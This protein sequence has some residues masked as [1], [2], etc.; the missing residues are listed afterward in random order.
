MNPSITTTP[1]RT[2][3]TN[4]LRHRW[5]RLAKREQRAVQALVL[6]A[7]LTSLYLLWQPQ[8]QALALAEQRYTEETQ[9]LLDLQRLPVST[10][11][12][13]G[14]VISGD[15]LPGMLA[16]SS[17]QA[18]L[19]LERM[20]QEDEGRVNLS[21]EGPLNGLITWID[22]LEQQQVAVLSFSIEVNKDAMASA[23]LQLHT[24]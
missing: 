5:Q 11:A 20:D 12:L 19:N 13:R 1:A 16:R 15:A 17:S 9:L 6:F 2:A 24:P 4:P 8:Q 10:S 18:G 21:L 23:R 22:Q 7:G 3:L 14:P